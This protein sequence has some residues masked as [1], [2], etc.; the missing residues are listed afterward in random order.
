[1]KQIARFVGCLTPP[2][3]LWVWQWWAPFAPSEYQAMPVNMGDIIVGSAFIGV[4]TIAL[5]RITHPDPTRR[6]K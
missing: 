6:N 5:L 4:I 1:V 3:L 2:T